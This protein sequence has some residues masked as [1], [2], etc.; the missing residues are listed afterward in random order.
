MDKFLYLVE[1]VRGSSSKNYNAFLNNANTHYGKPPDYGGI[2][3][4]CILAHTQD[5]QTVHLLMS[6]G[7]KGD[8]DDLTVTEITSATLADPD[9]AHRLF[10]STVDYFK[11]YN[12]LPN[13]D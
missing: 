6:D 2:K 8:G 9:S 7:F 10:T 3:N 11:K 4:L 12:T 5:Q 13:L 1:L